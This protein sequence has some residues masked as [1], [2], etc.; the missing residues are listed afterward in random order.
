[1][2]LSPGSWTVPSIR[3]AGL[4]FFVL[5]ELKS[6]IDR[7]PVTCRRA[8]SSEMMWRD[9]DTAGTAHWFFC[10]VL[11]HCSSLARKSRKSRGDAGHS[12]PRPPSLR[13]AGFP[14]DNNTGT[15]NEIDRLPE[16]P[17]MPEGEQQR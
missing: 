8:P 14:L 13:L 6:P 7:G 4:I 17:R 15:T 10:D 16:G 3:F 5:V 9:F 11:A 12:G 1:M 2:D